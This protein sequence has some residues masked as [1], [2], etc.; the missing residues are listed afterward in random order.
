MEEDRFA[1]AYDRS[2]DNPDVPRRVQ[3]V[4]LG[5]K[6]PGKPRLSL[7]IAVFAAAFAF[8]GIAFALEPDNT[9][10]IFN[11]FVVAPCMIGS[12]AASLTFIKLIIETFGS[13][14]SIERVFWIVITARICLSVGIDKAFILATLLAAGLLCSHLFLRF[15]VGE[16]IPVARG[17]TRV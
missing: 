17:R 16:F 2:H 15:V 4:I 14:G 10:W 5:R 6:I 8:M 11:T 1:A 3:E 9:N 12:L 13:F 7:L